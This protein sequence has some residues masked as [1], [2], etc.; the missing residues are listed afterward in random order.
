MAEM[1]PSFM[2]AV[3]RTPQLDRL[4]ISNLVCGEGVAD[5]AG[6]DLLITTSG[7]GDGSVSVAE[8]GAFIN[9]ESI[10]DQGM[11]SVFNDAP[12]LLGPFADNATGNPRIDTVVATVYD[13]QYGQPSN[14]WVMEVYPGVATVGA[15]LT[16]GSASYHLGAETD[17][18]VLPT[19][20]I[21]LGYVLVPT[22]FTSTST[23]LAGNIED[24][25]SNHFRCG[26]APYVTLS[27]SATQTGIASATA[28]KIDLSTITHLDQSYFTIAASVITVL[29]DGLYDLSAYVGATGTLN[30]AS[31]QTVAITRGGLSELIVSAL[32]SGSNAQIRNAPS[33]QSFPLSAGN[34]LQLMVS[35]STTA[36][37][38]STVHS[39]ASGLVSR[40]TVRKV[41]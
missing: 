17:P 11:Y 30:S 40:L 23:V 31:A 6:G 27:A 24:G 29:K 5:K 20:Y 34:T 15:N 37:T 9:G 21:V 26:S 18:L 33:A 14:S 39:P 7:A 2:Q 36:G 16:Y 8:G 41:G 13:G 4:V 25:R 1:S 38:V 32:V 28:T 19:N 3:C 22:G 12:R 35:V 10:A